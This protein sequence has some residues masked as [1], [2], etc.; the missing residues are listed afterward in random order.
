MVR[1][2]DYSH[3]DDLWPESLAVL[4]EDLGRFD[5]AARRKITCENAGRL[6]GLMK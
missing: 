3:P 2:S 4:E 6:Y 5:Q 1:G